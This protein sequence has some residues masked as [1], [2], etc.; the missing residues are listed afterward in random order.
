MQKKSLLRDQKT[1]KVSRLAEAVLRL[2]AQAGVEG[3][4]FSKLARAAGVSRAWIYKY[5]GT[6]DELL[7]FATDYFGKIFTSLEAQ[8]GN[9]LSERQW[10]EGTTESFGALL[11]HTRMHPLVVMLYFRFRGTPTL[12]G[13]RIARVEATQ[14]NHEIVQLRALFLLSLPEARRV[15]EVLGNIRMGL[16]HAWAYGELKDLAAVG[17]V[18]IHFRDAIEGVLQGL[19]RR[20]ARV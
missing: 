20:P 12:L 11:E 16:A 2:V 8:P 10:L 1:E 4:T 7:A 9:Y 3:L 5:G 18:K 19:K 17:E 14:A 13:K 15:S 6:R